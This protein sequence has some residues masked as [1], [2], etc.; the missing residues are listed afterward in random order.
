MDNDVTKILKAAKKLLKRKGGWTQGVLARRADGVQVQAEHKDAVSFC[1]IGATYHAAK[2]AG[3][4]DKAAQ[5][6]E[7]LNTCL[8]PHG[9]VVAFNDAARRK[10]SEVLALLDKA[11]NAA[12]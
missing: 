8:G 5:T 9:L 6:V 12:Q 7:H 2:A 11:I 4:S 1:L 3:L 10:K